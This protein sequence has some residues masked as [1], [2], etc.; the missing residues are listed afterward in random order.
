MCLVYILRATDGIYYTGITS[1][2]QRRIIQHF[3]CLTWFGRNH[4]PDR[5]MWWYDAKDRQTAAAVERKIK[6]QGARRFLSRQA[7]CYPFIYLLS[8]TRKT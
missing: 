1:N 2:L 8:L 7:S 5:L 3:S 6:R 4:T